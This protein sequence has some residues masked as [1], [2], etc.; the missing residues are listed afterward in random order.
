MSKEKYI[1]KFDDG[2]FLKKGMPKHYRN[3][4]SV[5]EQ[6]KTISEAR[7]FN[8]YTTAEEVR[9]ELVSIVFMMKCEIEIKS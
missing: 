1:I 3:G 6:V 2:T 7:I 4:T 8:D 9:A 5:I